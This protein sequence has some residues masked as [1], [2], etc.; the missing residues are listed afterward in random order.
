MTEQ[1]EGGKNGIGGRAK[2][3]SC[4]IWV[5]LYFCSPRRLWREGEPERQQEKILEGELRRVNGGK[6]EQQRRKV[7][8]WKY[9][10]RERHSSCMALGNLIEKEKIV[11][12]LL[13]MKI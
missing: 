1:N 8:I 3:L 9:I 4:S 10:Y 12:S 13:K 11:C 2:R 7:Y 6:I 5:F